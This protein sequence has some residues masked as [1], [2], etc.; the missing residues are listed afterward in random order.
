MNQVILTGNLTRDPEVRTTHSGKMRVTF[1]IAV[2][3]GNK[4]TEFF[5]LVAWDK[6]AE[7]IGKYF[8]KGK[9]IMVVGHLQTNNYTDSSGV[10]RYGVDII[11]D[12]VE[13]GGGKEQG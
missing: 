10:K 1:G 7:F 11:V 2:Q 4:E 5:N 3:Y 8:R 13:F 12:S 6:T 9:R